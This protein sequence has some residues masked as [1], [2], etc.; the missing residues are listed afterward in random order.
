MFIKDLVKIKSPSLKLIVRLGT[1]HPPRIVSVV[2]H[3]NV[4]PERWPSGRRRLI[5]VQVGGYTVSWVRIPPSPPLHQ[6]KQRVKL[7]I[8]NSPTLIPT[9]MLGLILFRLVER[10]TGTARHSGGAERASA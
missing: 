4:G 3:I 7:F 10:R 5:G 9:L 6:N 8:S 2:P 1:L